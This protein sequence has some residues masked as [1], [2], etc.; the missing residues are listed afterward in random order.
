MK[1]LIAVITV[2]SFAFA[3][4]A[5][6]VRSSSTSV[7]KA[8]VAGYSRVFATYSPAKVS[9][10]G[11]SLNLNSIQLGYL[12]GIPV[13][14]VPVYFET[15]GIVEYGFSGN[16]FSGLRLHIPLNLA[17]V[18]SLGDGLSLSPYAGLHLTGNVIA[19]SGN[20]DMFSSEGV[21]RFQL[22]FQAGIGFSYSSLYLGVGYLGDILSFTNSSYFNSKIGGLTLTLGLNF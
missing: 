13:A 9:V 17:Y 11:V 12:R 7:G 22:G 10:E 18:L 6:I 21:N 15:G 8:N 19:K 3:A 5:Q 2:L 14:T 16:D 20:E 4:N 1:K